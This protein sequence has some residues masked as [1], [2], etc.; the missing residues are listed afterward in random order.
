LRQELERFCVDTSAQPG[1]QISMLDVGS[2]SGDLPALGCKHF[3]ARGMACAPIALDRD[4]TAL[5]LARQNGITVIR[6]DA[7]A[8]PFARD[9]FEIVT[10]AKFAHHFSGPRLIGLIAEMARVAR[11]RVIVLDIRRD[12]LAYWGFVGWSRVFTRNR[13]VR[14]DGPVSVLRGFTEAELQ[15]AVSRLKKFS[16]VVRHYAGFQLALVGCRSRAT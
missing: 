5:A 14:Y 6:A 3:A 13:L 8:L 7:L 15:E 16:W 10:A 12:W 9:T 4:A 2:G 1:Q 11:K